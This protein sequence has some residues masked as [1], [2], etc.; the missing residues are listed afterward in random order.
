M[1]SG[2]SCEFECCPVS[3]SA[4]HSMCEGA[5]LLLQGSILLWNI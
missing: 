3:I 2:P 1:K 5:A 4:L